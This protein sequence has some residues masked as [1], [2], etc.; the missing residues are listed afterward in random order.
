MKH[1]YFLMGLVMTLVLSCSPGNG[2]FI[3]DSPTGKILGTVVV[4]NGSYDV[5]GKDTTFYDFI[6]NNIEA[7][8]TRLTD[9]TT[10]YNIKLYNVSFSNHMPVT[11]DMTIPG[12]DIDSRGNLSGDNIVPYAGILGEYP[13]Y[14]IHNLTG[15]VIF[16]NKGQ[17][18]A[19]TIE[20]ICGTF[21]TTYE[22]MYIKTE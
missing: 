15:K 5:S 22:G 20:M 11:I 12:V 7:E 8:L 4:T 18:G 14:T 16:D 9:D 3:P 21:P 1:Q 13:K 2:Q 10:K 17:A 19:L 6:C